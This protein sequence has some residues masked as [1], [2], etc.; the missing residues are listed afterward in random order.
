MGVD[1]DW[2]WRAWFYSTDHVDI[3]IT[4]IREYRIKSLN[5]EID[6]PLDR[7]ENARLEPQPISQQR[8]ADE[9]LVTR[10]ERFP[11]SETCTT[12]TISSP[13]QTKTVMIIKRNL[14]A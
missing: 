11:N 12:T 4:N 2:F 9:G 7:Q 5:P 10:L 6:Y 8:N 13:F 3:A 14:K 1:L